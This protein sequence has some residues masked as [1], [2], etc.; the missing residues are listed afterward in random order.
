MATQ[1]AANSLSIPVFFF[2]LKLLKI[3]EKKKLKLKKSVP[4]G[5]NILTRLLDRKQTFF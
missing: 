5:T 1:A 4:V 2:K 3:L